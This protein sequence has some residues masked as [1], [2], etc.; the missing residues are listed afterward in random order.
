MDLMV[1]NTDEELGVRGGANAVESDSAKISN[2]EFSSRFRS[3]R[4]L[5]R[6]RSRLQ[7]DR[8]ANSAAV[9]IMQNHSVGRDSNVIKSSLS[10]P[11]KQTVFDLLR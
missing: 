6:E 1:V 10:S 3:S 2:W 4:Y 8:S 9:H 11:R 5:Q 7:P